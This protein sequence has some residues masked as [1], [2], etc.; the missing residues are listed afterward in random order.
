M[1]R[2]GSAAAGA[3]AA[4][5]A[6]GAAGEGGFSQGSGGSGGGGG[7]C[8]GGGGG[9]GGGSSKWCRKAAAH[10]DADA[11]CRLGVCNVS[12]NGVRKGAGSC[13]WAGM[14]SS[15]WPSP[16][17]TPSGRARARRGRSSER[18]SG[19][20]R[21]A[22]YFLLHYY[23]IA[24]LGTIGR[25]AYYCIAYFV[26][27]SSQCSAAYWVGGFTEGAP[28]A[29]APLCLCLCLCLCMCLCLLR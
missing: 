5:G 1:T 6:A 22:Y 19:R 7:G 12:G 23:C 4:E 27:C 29:R 2:A 13:C 10:G 3:A 11:Q 24:L 15:A 28:I 21:Y 18:S 16:R 9:C 14:S 8:G 26:Q 20:P 25:C 17:S